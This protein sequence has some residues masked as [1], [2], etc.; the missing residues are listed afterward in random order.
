[1]KVKATASFAGIGFAAVPGETIDVPEAV[2]KDLIQA[3]FA[4]KEAATTATKEK[5]KNEDK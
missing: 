2:A 1:M 5:K 4:K 3:G